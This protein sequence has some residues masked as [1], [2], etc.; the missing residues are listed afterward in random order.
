MTMPFDAED[1]LDDAA[2]LARYAAGDAAAIDAD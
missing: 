1:E 2:L